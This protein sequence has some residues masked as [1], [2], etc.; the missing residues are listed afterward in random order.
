MLALAESSAAAMPAVSATGRYVGAGP[1]VLEA[2]TSPFSDQTVTIRGPEG[3]TI[4]ELLEL[5]GIRHWHYGNGTCWIEDAERR[6]E[7]VEIRREHWRRVRPKA[8]TVTSVILIPGGG[9]SGKMILRIVGM[10]AIMAAAVFGGPYLAG[11]AAP[12]LIGTALG[13]ALGAAFSAAIPCAGALL[14]NARRPPPV[15]P[16][17]RHAP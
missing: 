11:L 16:A 5:A 1:I 13:T 4:A 14:I 10:I 17:V 6:G 3:S 2:V 9:G 12:A 7:P 8:G 15:P